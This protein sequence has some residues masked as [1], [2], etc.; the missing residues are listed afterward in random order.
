[1]RCPQ[2]LGLFDQYSVTGLPLSSSEKL[3]T[4]FIQL[5]KKFS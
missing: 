3:I 4:S 2:T 5:N 1:M